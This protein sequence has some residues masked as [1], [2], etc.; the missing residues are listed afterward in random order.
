MKNSSIG[1]VLGQLGSFLHRYR[2]PF[3][4]WLYIMAMMA[5]AYRWMP[6]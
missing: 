3:L 4:F 6:E 1:T 5:Y 2:T